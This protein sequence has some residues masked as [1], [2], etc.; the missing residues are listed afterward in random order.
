MSEFKTCEADV[1]SQDNETGASCLEIPNSSDPTSAESEQDVAAYAY[2]TVAELLEPHMDRGD[3]ALLPSS[4]SEA[5]EIL[6]EYRL[7]NS[8]SRQELECEPSAFGVFYRGV[9][10]DFSW[11]RDAAIAISNDDYGEYECEVLPLYTHPAS[12]PEIPDSSDPESAVV[13]DAMIFD[14]EPDLYWNRGNIESADRGIDHVVTMIA[15]SMGLSSTDTF[16]I[17]QAKHLPDREV[18]ITVDS[19]GDVDWKWAEPKQEQVQ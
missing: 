15:D 9:L 19:E 8:A 13:P 16:P 3:G 18:C 2:H 4:V 11:S 5:V 17:M 14:D 7:A 1:E 6:L 10:Q 12:C